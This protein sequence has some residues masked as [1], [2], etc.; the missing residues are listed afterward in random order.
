VADSTIPDDSTYA[1]LRQPVFRPEHLRQPER[2]TQL[3]RRI[4]A[5]ALAFHIG[6]QPPSVSHFIGGPTGT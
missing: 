3:D 4:E 5:A 6:E 2:V 1:P